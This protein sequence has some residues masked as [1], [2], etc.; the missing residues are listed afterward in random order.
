M[1]YA[2]LCKETIGCF[3]KEKG[4]SSIRDFTRA[5]GIKRGKRMRDHS[6]NGDMDEFFINGEWKGKE[7]ENISVMNFHDD[8]TESLVS[9]CAW[10]DAWK[11]YGLEGYGSYYCRYID[12]AICE[13]YDGDFD[14]E[15]QS[16]IG[17][18]DGNCIFRWSGKADPEKV[19][20]SERHYILDFDH[21]CREL[22]ECAE[23]YLPE[24]VLEK[25]RDEFVS[26]FK[27][28]D[29]SFDV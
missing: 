14:L 16:A 3:G 28:E 8:C 5:Y 24:E 25:V 22:Y 20:N 6:V 11:E 7:G 15:L 4:E 10:Y 18:G 19:K 27:D 12:A 26:I 1:L 2:L 29:L 13:G 23:R 17:L 21:H 9:K